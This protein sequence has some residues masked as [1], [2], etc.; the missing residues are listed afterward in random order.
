MTYH[1]L[2]SHYRKLNQL[3]HVSRIVGWDE[4]VMMPPGAGDAR[5]DAMASLEGLIHQGASD[6]RIATWLAAAERETLDAL[7]RANLREVRRAHT[8]ATALPSELVEAQSRAQLRCEQAWRS[9]RKNQDWEGHL[10]LLSEVVRL[11]REE[12]SILAQKLGLS[13]YDALMDAFEP[14][15]RSEVIDGL[16]EDLSSWLP[17][18]IREIVERQAGQSTPRAEGPFP[19]E[20]QRAAG[21]ELMAALGFDFQH[22]RLDTSHHPFCG[23]VP[24]DVRIT[25]RYNEEDFTESLM[26]VLHETGHAKYEQGLPRELDGLPV[27][28]ARSMGVHESQSLFQEMQICRGL[29]FLRFA[30]PILARIFGEAA[31]KTPQAFEPESLF[32]LYIRV[33]PGFIRVDADEVTYPLHVI[34]RYRLERALI[35]GQLE[36]RDIPGV[37]D[38]SMQRSLGLST[39]GNYRD[40]CMQDV[41][42]PS[43]AFGYFPSYTL[44]ALIAAQ[45]FEA[46]TLALP[47]LESDIARGE[48]GPLNQFLGERVWSKASTLETAE[49]IE[50]ASGQELGTAAFKRHVERRYL[51]S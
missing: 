2:T 3:V 45:L 48:M 38:E 4:A 15:M 16:F 44:G 18:R 36:P 1:D 43:G 6:P 27:G 22:G 41:H 11:K 13:P 35:E 32:R 5:A 8:R 33:K 17:E 31:R 9:Q 25:T 10:P 46:A 24:S 39:R 26:G 7:G 29:P 12:A 51:A 49:L 42:W 47:T 23:G 40:G 30:G 28:Q 19:I 21:L 14:G 37:W 34:L 50:G 20:R